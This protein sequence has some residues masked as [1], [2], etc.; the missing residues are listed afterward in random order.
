MAER[1]SVRVDGDAFMVVA[2]VAVAPAAGDGGWGRGDG[3]WEIVGDGGNKDLDQRMASRPKSLLCTERMAIGNGVNTLASE[4]AV[5]KMGQ[6]TLACT[7]A[8]QA[9]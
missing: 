1:R 7:C 5:V 6:L 9:K 3:G 4:D 8:E 2:F